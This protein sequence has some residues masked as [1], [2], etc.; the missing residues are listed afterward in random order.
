MADGR[1]TISQRDRFAQPLGPELKGALELP[2]R[3][4]LEQLARPGTQ[5]AECYG[6]D[7]SPVVPVLG[8]A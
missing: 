4:A 1:H 5:R 8:A 6:F 3:A 2:R 7:A